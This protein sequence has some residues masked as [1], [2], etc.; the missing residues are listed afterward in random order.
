[1]VSSSVLGLKTLWDKML[2]YVSIQ[3]KFQLSRAS[4]SKTVTWKPFST[5]AAPQFTVRLKQLCVGLDK[6]FLQNG[7]I[8]T[9]KVCYN[10]AFLSKKVNNTGNHCQKTIIKGKHY[11]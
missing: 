11:I 4:K 8:H 5:V 6:E 3:S 2:G 10:L 9:N 7:G 1:M